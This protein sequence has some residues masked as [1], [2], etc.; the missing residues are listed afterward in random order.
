MIAMIYEKAHFLNGGDRALFIELGDSIEPELGKRVRLLFFTVKNA[1]IKGIM[2]V[3][4]TYASLLINYDPLIISYQELQSEL[5]S[6]E[7]KASLDTEFI[8][9]LITKI[10][11]VYGNG[12]GPDL[13]Y[14]SKHNGLSPAEVVQIHSGTK[15]LIYMLGFTP[16][17]AYLG[18]MSPKIA[19]PRLKT[20]RS[21]IPAGSVG[22]AGNQ[23]GIYP[24]ESPA[25]WQLIG[26]T[27]LKL[28]D[29]HREPPVLLRA[30]DFLTFVSV[31]PDE[32]ARISEQ[33]EQGTYQ[34]EVTTAH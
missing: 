23:T 8:K 17:F 4:P 32:Y 28:F 2:D 5:E 30:G 22:I 29:Q 27:P 9:P 11:T 12:F 1:R 21:S 18:G 7:N 13:E 16:G 3:T 34:P 10:P 19:T 33:I 14:V 20:P 26:R 25:G 24:L 15:Y 31:N 6:I